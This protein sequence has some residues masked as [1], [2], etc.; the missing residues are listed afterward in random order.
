MIEEIE[1]PNAHIVPK[2]PKNSVRRN[3]PQD[4]TTLSHRVQLAETFVGTARYR[5]Q[6]LE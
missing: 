2:G 5:V 6:I 4:P 1:S 3:F